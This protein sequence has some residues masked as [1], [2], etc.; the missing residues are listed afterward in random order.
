MNV[1]FLGLQQSYN[2][3]MKMSL[4]FAFI[5]KAAKRTLL[6]VKDDHSGKNIHKTEWRIDPS[7]KI[8]FD[9]LI[10]FRLT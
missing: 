8:H 1:E 5:Q 9:A 7:M 3:E 6:K 10:V 4:I 2:G